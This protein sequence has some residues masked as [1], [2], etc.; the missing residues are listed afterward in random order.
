MIQ[1]D[2]EVIVEARQ[3]AANSA[4]YGSPEAKSGTFGELI[5]VKNYCERVLRDTQAAYEPWAQWEAI[6]DLLAVEDNRE[7]LRSYHA[8]LSI[9]KSFFK[10]ALVSAARA[11]DQVQSNRQE[12]LSAPTAGLQYSLLGLAKVLDDAALRQR[13]ASRQWALD[14]GYSP[15][16]AD[17]AAADNAKRID[18]FRALVPVSWPGNPANSQLFNLRG[19]LKPLRD[20]ILSHSIGDPRVLSQFTID[21]VRE[22]LK[23][24]LALATDMQ[25]VF[26]GSAVPAE[27][28][29]EHCR[30]QADQFWPVAFEG[31]VKQHNKHQ[32]ARKAA[33]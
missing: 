13:L 20:N 23:L 30:E 6:N 27:A 25:L 9:R 26:S 3:R 32:A 28:W 14:L 12:I 7:A 24:S 10:E 2:L 1:D 33:E 16:R 5:Y 31:A 17:G 15:I 8:L 11:T 29:K 21:E 19:K 4:Q 18:E 22:L